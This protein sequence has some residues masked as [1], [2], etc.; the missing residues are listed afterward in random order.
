MFAF[1]SADLRSSSLSAFI[2]GFLA[3][4]CWRKGDGIVK[5]AAE[6]LERTPPWR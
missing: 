2:G 4:S 5:I 3:W 1:S 6:Y